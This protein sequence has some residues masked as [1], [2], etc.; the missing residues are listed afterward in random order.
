MPLSL[1]GMIFHNLEH[2]DKAT[3]RRMI[4]DRANFLTRAYLCP[5]EGESEP[6]V[7]DGTL[8]MI[9]GVMLSDKMVRE[10]MQNL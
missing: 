5:H 10:M 7:M 6:Q 4:S 9:S 3:K 2:S 1:C 8:F